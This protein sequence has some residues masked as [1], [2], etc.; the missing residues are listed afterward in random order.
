MHAILLAAVAV[1]GL[2]F[3]VHWGYVLV[4]SA[5]A[6][7]AADRLTTYWWVILAPA[8]I[9]AGLLDFAFQFTFGW[10]MFLETPFR[11]GAFF[12][13]R[14]QYHFRNG[15]GWRLDLARF[16]ARNLNV[17]DDHIK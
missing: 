17:F 5:K 7:I 1:A 10:I 12:S 16:W 8:A 15:E 9:V 14:V 11:G 6:A 4:M 3:G 2:F 13:G